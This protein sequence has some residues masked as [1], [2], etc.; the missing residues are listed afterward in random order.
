MP[1]PSYCLTRNYCGTLPL[2]NPPKGV[3]AER[4]NQHALPAQARQV[5]FRY[6]PSIDLVRALNTGKT[7][8]FR[9]LSCRENASEKRQFCLVTN[10]SNPEQRESGGKILL[11]PMS[12]PDYELQFQLIFDW[13]DDHA[14]KHRLRRKENLTGK[15]ARQ[16]TTIKYNQKTI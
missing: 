1:R 8:F 13:R 7:R 16:R 5:M 3:H 2:R 14:E 11:G 15:P 9:S 4:S 6:A 10:R 12:H